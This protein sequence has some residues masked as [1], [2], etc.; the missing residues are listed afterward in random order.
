MIVW[1]GS[2][3]LIDVLVKGKIDAMFLISLVMFIWSDIF[4]TIDREKLK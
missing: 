1:V 4:N 2:V 3:Y